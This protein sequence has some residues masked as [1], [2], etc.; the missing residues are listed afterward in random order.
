MGVHGFAQPVEQRT[1]RDNKRRLAGGLA[2][3]RVVRGR[4]ERPHRRRLRPVLDVRS[5]ALR[6]TELVRDLLQVRRK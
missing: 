2:A 1:E 5:A 6:P 3:V 4:Q